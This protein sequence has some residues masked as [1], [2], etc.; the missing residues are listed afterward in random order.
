MPNFLEN[1]CR[2]ARGRCIERLVMRNGMTLFSPTN[3][4]LIEMAEEIFHAKLYTPDGWEMDAG[5]VVV[6]IGANI[7]V[8]S[9]LAA[10]RHS[11]QVLAFEPHP[12][13]IRYLKRNVSANRLVN[14]AIFES[15]VSDQIGRKLLHVNTNAA[16]HSLYD[17]PA[18]DGDSDGLWVPT[19]T[20]PEIMDT[21]RLGWVDFLKMDCEG[22]EG[23]ILL[24][25]P[26]DYLKRIR[27]MAIEF[28]DNVS[29]IAHDQ[30]Q[31]L[32]EQHGFFTAL[33]W[34]EDTQFGFLYATRDGV[35]GDAHRG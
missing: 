21:N 1:A 24:S 28:H 13:N 9:V 8:F 3:H 23:A 34:D 10:G 31:S 20:L 7:G 30:I 18:V 26:T 5:G 19:T 11:S 6:D 12:E 15:A 25:A 27:R 35:D 2:I 17:R 33:R 32:L 22:A 16:S 4:P 29:V 14:V